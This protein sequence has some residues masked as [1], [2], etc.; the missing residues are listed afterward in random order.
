MYRAYAA[1][2]PKAHALIER[3]VATTPPFAAFVDVRSC[4]TDDVHVYT[5][6][7]H[8]DVHTMTCLHTSR[9]PHSDG[10]RGLCCLRLSILVPYYYVGMSADP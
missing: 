2:L 9:L 8:E 7:W 6:P 5:V 4:P 3:L 10:P 1:N